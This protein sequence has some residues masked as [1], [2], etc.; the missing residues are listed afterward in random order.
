MCASPTLSTSEG[1][2]PNEVCWFRFTEKLAYSINDKKVPEGI[3]EKD[4]AEGEDRP[5]C[6][7]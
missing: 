5:K 3:G 4:R 6:N 1:F 2:F 7:A